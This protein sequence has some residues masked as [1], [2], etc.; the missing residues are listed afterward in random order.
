[1]LEE[2]GSLQTYH[3]K[4]IDMHTGFLLTML[5]GLMALPLLGQVRQPKHPGL[6]DYTWQNRLLLVFAPSRDHT[7]FAEQLQLFEKEQAA[8]A[9]RDL[10]LLQVVGSTRW[11]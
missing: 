11:R 3:P 5:L 8:F 10:F 4:Q 7:S 2:S 1:M 6:K 9:E